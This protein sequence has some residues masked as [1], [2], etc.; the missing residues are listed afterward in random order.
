M[1]RS[2]GIGTLWYGFQTFLFFLFLFAFLLLFFHFSVTFLSLLY[3]VNLIQSGTDED[4]TRN[5]AVSQWVDW[6]WAGY[7][8][9]TREGGGFQDG[10]VVGL[11]A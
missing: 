10:W 8:L 5:E 11:K 1:L 3:R 9:W 6:V 4:K 7:G 2:V